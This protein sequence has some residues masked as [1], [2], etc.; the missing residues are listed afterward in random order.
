M[1]INLSW[2]NSQV[3]AISA[4][5][6]TKYL[7]FPDVDIVIFSSNI[8][9]AF[10]MPI[11]FGL[12]YGI[13]TIAGY[14]MPNPVLHIYILNIGFVNTLWRYTQLKDQTSLFQ[15]IEFSKSQQS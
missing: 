1:T 8:Y 5:L 9:L 13:L 11:S 2:A 14:L 3:I 4:N 7:K 6:R 10:D 12:A 15:A